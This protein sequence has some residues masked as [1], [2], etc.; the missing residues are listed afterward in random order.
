MENAIRNNINHLFLL[1]IMNTICLIC[2]KEFN[3]KPYLLKKGYGKFCSSEC[4]GIYQREHS[5]RKGKSSKININ[6]D[7]CGK[8]TKIYPHKLKQKFHFCNRECQHNFQKEFSITYNDS[9]ISGIRIDY[10]GKNWN[11]QSKLA[12][13][14]DKYIC[15][16]CGNK[17]RMFTIL[18]HT[19]YLMGIKKRM[20]YQI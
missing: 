20:I 8:N 19:Y 10:R 1:F 17:A 13:E 6:C 11:K 16:K 18:F 5:Y 4:Y 3:V 14:R 2:K 12:M 9:L 15:Q 7:Y